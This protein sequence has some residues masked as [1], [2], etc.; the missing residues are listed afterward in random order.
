M[1]G[2][3]RQRQ[4]VFAQ[5]LTR[6]L[7][8]RNVLRHSPQFD[9]RDLVV[10]L[11]LVAQ[12]F[13]ELAERP[14]IDR[15]VDRD[16]HRFSLLGL[17]ADFRLFDFVGERADTADGLVDILKDLHPLLAGHEFDQHFPSAFASFAGDLANSLHAAHGF[18]DRPQNA[19]FDFR[20]CG[21]GI[22][23]ADL[24]N[25]QLKSWK[26]LLLNHN[27]RPQPAAKQDRPSTGWRRSSCG[28]SKRWGHDAR[29]DRLHAGSIRQPPV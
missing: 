20:G 15:A 22:A 12:L 17:Q 3:F 16:L 10:G 6:D 1:S 27:R 21:T 14:D 7:H 19:L 23:D 29:R 5:S 11:Q 25:V 9:L 4:P 2:D 28:P 18:L 24:D 8:V 13:G 26:D